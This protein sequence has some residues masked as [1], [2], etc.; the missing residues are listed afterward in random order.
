MSDAA[1]FPPI[2]LLVL[3]ILLPDVFNF[4]AVLFSTAFFLKKR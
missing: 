2:N 3:K 1:I 4:L